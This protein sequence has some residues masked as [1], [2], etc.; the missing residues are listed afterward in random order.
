MASYNDGCQGGITASNNFTMTPTE[1]YNNMNHSNVGKFNNDT[2][3]LMFLARYQVQC[4][5]ITYSG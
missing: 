2:I 5:V 4:A 1:A 3:I